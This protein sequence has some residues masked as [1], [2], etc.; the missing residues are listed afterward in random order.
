M[1]DRFD[2]VKRAT[3]LSTRLAVIVTNDKS[4]I[5]E[6]IIMKNESSPTEIEAHIRELID[7][8]IRAVR[9]KNIDQALNNYDKDVLSFDVVD[10][11]QFMGIE[12]IRKRLEQW[13]STFLGP[14]ENEINDLKMRNIRECSF[15]VPG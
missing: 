11:L 10:P 6:I 9:D 13:F 8:Q 14:I 12:S 15:S 3:A 5:D 1:L 7:Q 4:Y 2:F